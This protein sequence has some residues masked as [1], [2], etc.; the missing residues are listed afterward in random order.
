MSKSVWNWHATWEVMNS[1][2][3][4]SPHS[5]QDTG[6]LWKHSRWHP[7]LRGQHSK[8]D[9]QILHGNNSKRILAGRAWSSPYSNA[10]EA[11]C[12]GLNAALPA[13]TLRRSYNTLDAPQVGIWRLNYIGLET[14]GICL[15]VFPLSTIWTSHIQ[16]LQNPKCSKIQN[17]MSTDMTSQVDYTPWWNYL[18]YC[19]KLSSGYLH[20]TYVKKKW[21]YSK[22]LFNISLCIFQ[23]PKQSK[24]TDF[25]SQVLW[26]RKPPKYKNEHTQND[27]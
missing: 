25:Q 20:K 16:K 4:L 9:I 26:I 10:K 27:Y 23:S 3:V 8:T 11:F 2:C 19:I 12:V 1:V 7:S 22:A 17:V 18:K 13:L 24:I 15:S 6:P 21:I 5:H 14:D